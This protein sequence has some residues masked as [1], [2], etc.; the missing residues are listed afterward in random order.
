M[1]WSRFLPRVPEDYEGS[2]LAFYFLVVIAILSSVRS[3][4]HIVAPDGGA[5]SIAGLALAVTGG[6]DIVAMFAQ[7]GASQ[8][9]L[10][11]FYWLAILRYRFLIPFMLAIVLLEQL[12]RIGIG[13]LKPLEVASPPPGAIGSYI[14]LPLSLIALVL[15][16]RR[17][18]KGA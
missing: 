16:L 8:L 5:N 7:W 12:L 6:A 17:A 2:P 10:T 11:V 14:V 18:S 3:L 9:I 1:N 13:H 4:I 15:S